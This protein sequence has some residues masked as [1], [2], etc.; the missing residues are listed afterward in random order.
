MIAA[1]RADGHI[2]AQEQQRIF[3]AVEHLLALLIT[4]IKQTLF[5]LMQLRLVDQT[6]IDCFVLQEYLF[7]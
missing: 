5:M 6:L 1:A 4:I 3:Q 7:Q 2:D